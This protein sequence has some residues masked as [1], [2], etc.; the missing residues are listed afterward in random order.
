MTAPAAF[1]TLADLHLNIL[2]LPDSRSIYQFTKPRPEQ[3]D[4]VDALGLARLL[5]QEKVGEAIH[6]R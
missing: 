3:R 5:D 2:E 1:E 4:L 6:P